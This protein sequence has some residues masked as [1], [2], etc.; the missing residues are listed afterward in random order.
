MDHTQANNSSVPIYYFVELFV[1]SQHIVKGPDYWVKFLE[2]STTQIGRTLVILDDIEQPCICINAWCALEIGSTY[3]TKRVV[4]PESQAAAP[5]SL[6]D[7]SSSLS[8][9]AS[10]DSSC[11]DDKKEEEEEVVQIIFPRRVRERLHRRIQQESQTS[12]I[13]GSCCTPMA[14]SNVYPSVYSLHQW[15]FRQTGAYHAACKELKIA[16]TE[17]KRGHGKTLRDI[18]TVTTHRI[19]AIISGRIGFAYLN[20]QFNQAIRTA[21]DRSIHALL[22]GSESLFGVSSRVYDG[23]YDYES[24]VFQDTDDRFGGTD[25]DRGILSS[26][27]PGEGI[28]EEFLNNFKFDTVNYPDID[29]DDEYYSNSD[30]DYECEY[31]FIHQRFDNVR[32]SPKTKAV[33]KSPSVVLSSPEIDQTNS[34]S[35]R[36]LSFVPKDRNNVKFS[37]YRYQQNMI[38]S[39]LTL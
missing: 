28:H 38:N 3:A 14:Y 5:S 39:F 22:N 10:V 17:E 1:H 21:L 15:D 4:D 18:C 25:D 30:V 9:V 19:H 13:P 36:T 32:S 7:D 23:T 29:D 20:Q 2:T 31:E 27:L 26:L 8:S 37:T 16:C 33:S 12:S 24:V 11:G 6:S 35:I 34:S